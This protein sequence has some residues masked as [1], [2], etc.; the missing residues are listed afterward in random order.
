MHHEYFL[1]EQDAGLVSSELPSCEGVEG[2]K[3]EADKARWTLLKAVFALL[4]VRWS[5]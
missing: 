3:S 5:D 2:P 1:Q 4:Q